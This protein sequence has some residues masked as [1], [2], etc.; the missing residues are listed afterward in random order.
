MWCVTVHCVLGE[1]KKKKKKNL[2]IILWTFFILPYF[3]RFMSSAQRAAVHQLLRCSQPKLSGTRQSFTLMIPLM[4]PY[5][6]IFHCFFNPARFPLYLCLSYA[7][8]YSAYT[9]PWQET[10]IAFIDYLAYGC[11]A[12]FAS[13]Y[14]LHSRLA[15]SLLICSSVTLHLFFYLLSL[16]IPVICVINGR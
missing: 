3:L 1:K 11:A 12:P 13:T 14:C 6:I 2:L 7:F 5:P 15:L 4:F 9:L 16:N 8:R 10:L